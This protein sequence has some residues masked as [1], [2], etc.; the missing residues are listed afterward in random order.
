MTESLIE[1]E[2]FGHEKGAYIGAGSRHVGLIEE[3]QG[4]TVF[5]DE[6]GELPQKVQ[7]KLLCLLQDRYITLSSHRISQTIALCSAVNAGRSGL[8]RPPMVG[9]RRRGAA[10]C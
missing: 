8:T 4:G 1:S 10:R 6:F 2:L 7:V 5:Y 3:A 9:R